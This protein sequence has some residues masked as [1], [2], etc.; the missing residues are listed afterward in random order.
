MESMKK[1]SQ[2]DARYQW[3][4]EDI[5]ASNEAWEEDYKAAKEAVKAVAA[6]QGKLGSAEGLLAGVA[7]MDEATRTVTKLFTFARMRR[8]E[9]NNVSAYQALTARGGDGRCDVVYD[10]GAAGHRQGKD[11]E[12]LCP[13]AQAGGLPPH[14][15]ER[16][17]HGGAHP[18]P[19]GGAFAGA[20]GRD[21]QR[22]G[23]HLLHAHRRR[24]YLWHRQG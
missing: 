24:F 18:L 22:A 12:L 10:P 13:G 9:D 21:G 7:A 11:R 23:Y 3:K 8:D 16:A 2:M 14:H 15:R 4:L 17:A 1:R 5:Y 19:C 20:G 6:C